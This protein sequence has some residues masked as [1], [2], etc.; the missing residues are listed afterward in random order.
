MMRSSHKYLIIL[1]LSITSCSESKKTS[2]LP[3]SSH[4]PFTESFWNR[5]IKYMLTRTD[6]IVDTTD[7]D[8]VGN[9]VKVQMLGYDREWRQFD[10]SHRVTRELERGE[11]PA[12][13]V[14][15]YDTIDNYVIKKLE[16]LST[17]QWK[18]DTLETFVRKTCYIL[19]RV[20]ELNRIIEEIDT[21][22]DNTITHYVYDNGKLVEKKSV[23]VFDSKKVKRWEFFYKD[24]VLERIEMYYGDQLDNVQ[25]FDEQ[26]LLKFTREIPKPGHEEDTL[27]HSYI[28]N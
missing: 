27:F 10:N 2:N 26:G 11:F 19:Y 23:N 8:T 9:M 4:D 6:S 20:D 12:H 17:A 13:F 16:L 5:N 14:V 28:Y 3:N 18:P 1:L 7:F 21:Y 24:T 15:S 25:H 22:Q